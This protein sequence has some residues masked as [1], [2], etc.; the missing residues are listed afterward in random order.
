[1]VPVF[2]WELNNITVISVL[3]NQRNSTDTKSN[4]QM[5][6]IISEKYSTDSFYLTNSF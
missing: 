4:T 2:N 1:M 5:I 6:K 3:N